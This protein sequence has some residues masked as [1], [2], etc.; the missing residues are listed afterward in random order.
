MAFL[1]Q[2]NVRGGCWP[3]LPDTRST[4]VTKI[5]TRMA[6]LHVSENCAGAHTANSFTTGKS[7]L[8]NRSFFYLGRPH[9]LFLVD[10]S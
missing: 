5:A 6:Y 10:R 1:A 7:I 4:P 8:W 2:G 3:T 9:F